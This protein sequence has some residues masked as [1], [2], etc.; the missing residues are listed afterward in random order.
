MGFAY[1]LFDEEREGLVHDI[2]VKILIEGKIE[3]Y[4]KLLVYFEGLLYQS[5]YILVNSSCDQRCESV[6]LQSNY[7][8][9]KLYDQYLRLNPNARFPATKCSY[10][11]RSKMF[12][13]NIIRSLKAGGVDICLR[14]EEAL[15]FDDVADVESELLQLIAQEKKEEGDNEGRS[16]DF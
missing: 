2:A 11:L 5:G 16:Y 9:E 8:K 4:K 12:S 15:Y 6:S 10:E 3:L 7:I 13:E 14:S 1:M